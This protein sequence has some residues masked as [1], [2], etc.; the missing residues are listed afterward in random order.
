MI[1][2]TIIEHAQDWD[3]K[4]PMILFGYCCRV[5]VNTKFSLRMLTNRT[6]RL[7]VDNFL[8]PLVQTFDIYED[9]AIMAEQMISKLQLITKMHG[10]V[11][12]NICQG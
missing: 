12:S 9:L 10:E 1:L 7:K 4:L 8:S 6:P 3:E 11:T 2:S 5:Q